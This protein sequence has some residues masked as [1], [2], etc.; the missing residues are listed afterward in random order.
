MKMKTLTYKV[1]GI[2]YL[3]FECPFPINRK[4]ELGNFYEKV[5]EYKGI[6]QAAEKINGGFWEDSYLKVSV[7]IPEE[8]AI[9]FSGTM[10]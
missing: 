8:K 4:T 7:L 10:E 6:L 1:N 3:L 5:K 9:E 2:N